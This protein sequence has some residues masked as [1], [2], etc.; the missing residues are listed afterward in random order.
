MS[1]ADAVAFAHAQF[2]NDVAR[3]GAGQWQW[4]AWLTPKG[5]VTATFALIKRGE[6]DLL[7]IVPDYRHDSLAI[8]L[9]RFIFRR[10]VR[11]EARADLCPSGTF[12]A[13]F[14]AY[15]VRIDDRGE[16][17]E[18]DYG[19]SA[20]RRTL[21]IAGAAAPQTDGF[22]ER[23]RASDLRH[24][25]VRLDP[26]Q[27]EQWT[28][29]QLALERLHAFSVRKGCYPGQEI[30]ARTHFLGKAKRSLALLE[31]DTPIVAGAEVCAEGWTIGT[32]VSVANGGHLA[33]AVLPLEREAMALTTGPASLREIAVLDGLERPG[34]P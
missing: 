1:G 14:R 12:A 2:A 33:A 34:G 28:P 18:L 8:S 7:L 32:V 17:I 21:R 4:N 24:G 16:E 29:Q 13:P 15:S 27:R 23:W 25:L 20:E 26:S 22:V 31:S 10:K 3:L 30:V 19:G 6:T 9:Q 11:I 5:R